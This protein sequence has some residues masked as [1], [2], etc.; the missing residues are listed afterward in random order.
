MGE[1]L[2]RQCR[3]MRRE[4]EADMQQTSW[5]PAKYAVAGKVL[6][7]RGDDGA[8]QDGWVV[9]HVGSFTRTES[10]ANERSRD[11]LRTRK[12]SDI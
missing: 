7:L 10:E 2:Y 1:T 12:A 6:K 3:L 11:H 4:G 5:I 8:W 9:S